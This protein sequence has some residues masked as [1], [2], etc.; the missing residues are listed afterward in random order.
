[1]DQEI[2]VSKLKNVEAKTHVRAA[3]IEAVDYCIQKGLLE[4]TLL[5]NFKL[6]Q[7]GE[8]FLNGII[9]FET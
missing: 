8:D 2:I 1:M 4:R 7:K 9:R 5:V 3:S 6:S